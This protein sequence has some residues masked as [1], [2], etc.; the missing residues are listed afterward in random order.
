V[1]PITRQ[2][3][4]TDDIAIEQ[5]VFQN[6]GG[7]VD[8]GA[9]SK[10]CDAESGATRSLM[11]RYN[12]G[13]DMLGEMHGKGEAWSRCFVFLVPFHGVETARLEQRLQHQTK[14]N[15]RRASTND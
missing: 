5:G 10:I 6:L 15:Q 8:D 4:N 2:Q 13:A 12:A 3:W 7:F 14:G 11:H 1:K 9:V